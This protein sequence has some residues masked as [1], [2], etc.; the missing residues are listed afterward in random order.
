[1]SAAAIQVFIR[2]LQGEYL[3]VAGDNWFLTPDRELAHVFDYLADNVAVQLEDAYRDLG[4]AW[5]AWPV[6]PHLLSEI[7]DH[8][9]RRL[10]PATAIFDGSGFFCPACLP[11]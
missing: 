10:P 11:R 9:A 4:V 5:V 1:M 6:D 7:C 2:N 3:S 8:C